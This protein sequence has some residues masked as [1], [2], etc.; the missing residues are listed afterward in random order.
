MSLGPS[1][2]RLAWYF[3]HNFRPMPTEP[4]ESSEDLSSSLDGSIRPSSIPQLEE[5]QNL[6]LLMI[7]PRPGPGPRAGP[8]Q[9]IAINLVTCT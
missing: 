1:G 4:M 8:G 3:S 7:T 6:L 2:R 5:S 9:P